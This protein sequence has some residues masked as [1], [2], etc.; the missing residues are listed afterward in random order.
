MRKD[1]KYTLIFVVIGIL[2]LYFSYNTFS[3]K[4]QEETPISYSGSTD[5]AKIKNIDY[6]YEK[7]KDDKE[8]SVVMSEM[9]DALRYIN[10]ILEDVPRAKNIDEYYKANKDAIN[11]IYALCTEEQ[12]ETFY[13]TIKPVERL[14]EYEMKNITSKF[15]KYHLEV[16]LTGVKTVKLPLDIYIDDINTL[17]CTSYWSKEHAL[18]D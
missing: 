12:F 1:V 17:E 5:M 16:E 2:G 8:C 11:K 9:T 4:I 7:I 6:V 10:I 3:R 15:S 13:K 18:W 14:T